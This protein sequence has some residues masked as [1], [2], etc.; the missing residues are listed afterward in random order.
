M[1]ARG[2]LASDAGVLSAVELN[3]II[4]QGNSKVLADVEVKKTE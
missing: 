1:G 2:D 3:K 4:V